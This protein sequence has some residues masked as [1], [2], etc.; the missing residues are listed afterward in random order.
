[1]LV[2]S[3]CSHLQPFI[4]NFSAKGVVVVAVNYRLGVLGFF[5]L[6]PNLDVEGSKNVALWGLFFLATNSS[7]DI[8][9][10]LEWVQK[11]IANFGGNPKKVTLMGISSGAILADAVSY[12]CLPLRDLLGGIESSI[13]GSSLSTHPQQRLPHGPHEGSHSLYA[14]LLDF[15]LIERTSKTLD[16]NVKLS[17]EVARR[18][19]CLGEVEDMEDP[20]NP[21]KVLFPSS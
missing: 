9:A 13:S 7:A 11:E 8:I 21:F 16:V 12:P 10:S 1:M 14:L 15:P 18:V 5:N 19:G 4:D 20:F 3:S 17:S 6:A 2:I